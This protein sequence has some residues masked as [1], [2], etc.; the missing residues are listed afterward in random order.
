M[1][2]KILFGAIFSICI[3]I[4]VNTSSAVEYKSV[5]DNNTNLLES[6]QKNID[7]FIEKIREKIENLNLKSIDLKSTNGLQE[8]SD[9]LFELRISYLNNPSLPMIFGNLKGLILCIILSLIGTI[10]GIIF[11]KIFGHLIVLIVK[12]LTAP[13]IL[14][15]K[16][17]E[18]IV[19]LIIQ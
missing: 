19:R 16:I 17:I 10:F 7:I 3:I 6:K 15:A 4:L 11:G 12:I 9:K 2:K 8:L 14:L 13:A 5:T 18:F 1:K